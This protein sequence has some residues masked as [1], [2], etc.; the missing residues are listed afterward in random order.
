MDNSHCRCDPRST[1]PEE[2]KLRRTSLSIVS[3]ATEPI[4]IVEHNGIKLQA[5][6]V[7]LKLLR[8]PTGRRTSVTTSALTS[9]GSTTNVQLFELP[10]S[11]VGKETRG[12]KHTVGTSSQ[13]RSHRTHNTTQHR[14]AS[15][16]ETCCFLGPKYFSAP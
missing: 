2:M 11:S 3:I 5:R 1:C 10:C 13:T 9:R 14:Q 15:L 8:L 7:M 6:S 4:Q 16:E 12:L